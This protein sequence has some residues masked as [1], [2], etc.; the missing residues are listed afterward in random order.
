MSLDGMDAATRLQV[1]TSMQK[2]VYGNS[3]W[4]QLVGHTDQVRDIAFG[5]NRLMASA[6]RDQTVR[7]WDLNGQMKHVLRGHK[8][9]VNS[10]EFSP[11]GR[12]LISSSADKTAKI[13]SHDGRIIKTLYG[14]QGEVFAAKFS[15][16]GKRIVTAGSDKNIR[17]WDNNGNLL[18][19]LKGHDYSVNTIAFSPSGEVFV[20]GSN[21][22]TIR[23][24]DRRATLIKTITGH[25]GR[26]LSL[27]FSPDGDFIASASDDGMVKFWSKS[28][29]PL[30]SFLGGSR[31]VVAQAKPASQSH[32][33][34]GLG[35][36]AY[37]YLLLTSDSTND[38][39]LWKLFSSDNGLSSPQ[40]MDTLRGHKS[41]LTSVRF[42]RDGITM[43]S[44]SSDKTIR[45]WRS[46]LQ[47]L[48]ES[49]SDLQSS[50]VMTY[51]DMKIEIG[52]P[53]FKSIQILGANKK[54]IRTLSGHS[55]V[56]KVA[57]FLPGGWGVIS[58]S[59]DNTLRLWSL[60]DTTKPPIIMKTG[61]RI[62]KVAVSPDGLIIASGGI[63]N[64]VLLWSSDGRLLNQLHLSSQGVSNL[65]FSK[66]GKSLISK[67]SDGLV[68]KWSFDLGDL[69]R[70][71]CA[72]LRNSHS[73]SFPAC[74]KAN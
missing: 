63:D 43:A 41:S 34:H 57:T 65:G 50:D 30:G 67:A 48:S 71:G 52:K 31:V 2:L 64:R 47:A 33:K 28:G 18:N 56:V 6:G 40:L 36:R 72:F 59:A 69:L 73:N 14:H 66:D 9:Q 17:V 24:W 23:L 27:S 60:S 13:W 44:S 55:A 8:G 39:H 62:T 53:D 21:D 1:T 74:R 12:R 3:E 29:N 68:Y 20:S 61:G 70:R 7:I 58:G 42:S 10:V 49:P 26:I 11:D 19:T 51:K 54:V 46:P 4:L 25:Q 35:G 45:L 37:P 22:A 38:L 32:V 15:P 16:D 5:P